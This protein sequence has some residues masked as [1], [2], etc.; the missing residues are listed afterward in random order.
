[1]RSNELAQQ[2]HREELQRLKAEDE[3]LAQYIADKAAQQEA[4][5]KRRVEEKVRRPPLHTITLNLPHSRH[6]H[7]DQHHHDQHHH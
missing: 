1:V 4:D 2:M 6:L 5:E 3:R 7:H